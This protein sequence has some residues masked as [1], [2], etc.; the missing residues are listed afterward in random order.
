MDSRELALAMLEWEEL[1]IKANEIAKKIE[2]TVLEL[3]KTQ[4]VGSV[5]ASY[6]KGRGKYDY[7]TAWL[8]A[9]MGDFP[10]DD[11]KVVTYDY[12]QACKDTEIKVDQY[13]SKTS[14]PSVSLKLL[15]K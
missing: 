8:E 5:R 11:Y 1:I 7:E 15:S 2:N 12:R 9:M 13:Y 10:S 3:E 6:S 14:G 4:T